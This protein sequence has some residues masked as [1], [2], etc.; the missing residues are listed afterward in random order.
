MP[1][2]PDSSPEPERP[3]GQPGGACPE[4]VTLAAAKAAIEQDAGRSGKEHWAAFEYDSEKSR[5][6]ECLKRWA[7]ASGA[8][9]EASDVGAWEG[10]LG[11]GEHDIKEVD[12]RMWKATKGGRFG[13]YLNCN[14]RAMADPIRQLQKV[15]GTP[16][17]YLSR[18]VL[19]N[20]WCHELEGLADLPE[21]TRLEGVVTLDNDFPSS[22][23]NPASLTTPINLM[24]TKFATGSAVWDFERQRQASTIARRTSSRSSM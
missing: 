5:E 3:S 4:A 21:L 17:Q 16:H 15:S 7:Y 2:Q 22:L 20:E 12:N 6:I 19:L 13:I 9:L 8:W 14:G 18:L 24:P 10:S 23:R 1:T 11:M